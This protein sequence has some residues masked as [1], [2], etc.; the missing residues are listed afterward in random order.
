MNKLSQKSQIEIASVLI[1][2]GA[3][4]TREFRVFGLVVILL[5][6]GVYLLFRSKT[7]IYRLRNYA[8]ITNNQRVSI[9]TG[10]AMLYIF[11]SAIIS[12]EISYFLLLVA[13]GV[14]Y[15]ICQKTTMQ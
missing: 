10:L 3:L 12:S 13:M 2:L 8:Q 14:D 11:G 6:I 4:I 1:V 9:F 7:L 5:T 15:F